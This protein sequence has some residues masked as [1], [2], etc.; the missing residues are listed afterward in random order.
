[1]A[2][3]SSSSAATLQDMVD[4]RSNITETISG[5][6]V[7]MVMD[8]SEN[9]PED[10]EMESFD[11]VDAPFQSQDKGKGK[12][13]EVKETGSEVFRLMDLPTEIRL[14]I[15]RACL[16]RPYKILLSKAEQPKSTVATLAAAKEREQ[17][18][19]SE[20]DI[21][22]R[23]DAIAAYQQLRADRGLPAADLSSRPASSN[24]RRVASSVRHLARNTSRH[25]RLTPARSS[26]ASEASALSS[27]DN[28]GTSSSSSSLATDTR[29]VRWGVK[30][31]R[32]DRASPADPLV[33]NILRAS[34]E[35]YKEARS[36]LYSENIFDLSLSTA[37]PS[38]AALHQRSRRHIKHVELEI[39][40]YTE[41]L[42]RFSEVVRLSLRYCSGLKKFVIH[43]PFTLPSADNGNGNVTASSSASNRTVYAN[44][45]DILRWL[46]QQCEVVLKGCENA[47]IEAVVGKH[48]KLAKAQD[49]VSYATLS[50][51]GA[52]V[53]AWHVTQLPAY[54]N[55]PLPSSKYV[56]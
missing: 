9:L 34:K 36:I 13:V 22:E 6:D 48:L 44:G 30:P 8:Q 20:M 3:A 49:K 40:T 39:P 18:T 55:P 51:G 4:D 28:A 53:R 50:R 31:P 16:T 38:L 54:A 17:E 1:M 26:S 24:A 5:N 45:F 33:I 41:I 35:I 21:E 43:T 37:V 14:E 12:L 32:H 7:D 47:E 11:Y 46:P 27:I 15:Y 19:S 10:A 42:E 52:G 23:G 2:T 29:P 25:M 56:E